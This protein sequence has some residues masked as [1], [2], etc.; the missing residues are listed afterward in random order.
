M[1]LP[2]SKMYF[3]KFRNYFLILLFTG[4]CNISKAQN[5]FIPASI[6][7]EFLKKE[8]ATVE[9]NYLQKIKSLPSQNKNDFSK[10]Y[11][12]R[13]E[14]IR[15]FFDSKE[16]YTNSQAQ[17]YLDAIVGE[18]IRSNP[19]LQNKNL[20]CYFSR[21]GDYNAGFYGEGM[22]LF[23]MGLF[24]KLE[25]ESQV[26]FVL[27]HEL[28]H[29]YLNHMDKG[30][31]DYVNKINSSDFQK[32]LKNI[33]K[34]EYGKRKEIESLKQGM[35]FNSRRHG[36]YHESM[37]DSLGLVFLANTRFD[38]AE[39][40]S[41]LAMLD[42]IDSDSLSMETALKS[43]FN[44]PEYPF[45]DKWLKKE[46]GLLGGHSRQDKTELEDSLKTHPDCL[47][48]VEFLKPFVEKYN[49]GL[50]LKNAINEVKFKELQTVFKYEIVEYAYQNKNYSASL[51]YTISLLQNLYDPYLITQIG[52]IFNGMYSAQ[53]SHTLNRF[54]QL[55]SP[56]FNS[57]YNL[58]L[59]FIQKLYR[60]DIAAISYNF[61]K[62]Y[63]EQIKNYPAFTDEFDLS[64]KNF[65]E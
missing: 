57:N 36:R 2:N 63:S 18:I 3:L 6:N 19:E 28:A 25:N 33:N 29:F 12:E 49:S 15:G 5:A 23:N 38:I 48:R 41:S 24:T 50:R 60:Y 27:C 32:Q 40:L 10:I 31:E 64:I 52:K 53:K 55:P 42:N 21:A 59:E 8:S 1:G 16:I 46:E 22:I 7:E 14:F 56:G 34:M 9:A 65:N 4:S 37:A 13:K 11:K 39:S 61:L 47:K 26:A 17:E 45:K 62:K 20:K 43:L 44:L 30:I 51:K 58:L 54:V 35:V